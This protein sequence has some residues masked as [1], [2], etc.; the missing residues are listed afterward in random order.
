MR[1]GRLGTGWSM[2]T[3]ESGSMSRATQLTFEEQ[4]HIMHVIRQ[5]ELLERTEMERVGSDTLNL[6][7]RFYFATDR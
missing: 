2:H 3:S 7:S 1:V 4:E 6:R 5:A